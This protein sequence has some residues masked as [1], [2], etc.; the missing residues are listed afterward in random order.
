MS[1]ETAGHQ[2][3][4][5][6]LQGNP[7]ASRADLAVAV[8]DLVA[9]LERFRSP[10]GA[11]VRLAGGGASYDQVAAEL[12][13]FS[14]PLWGLVPLAAGGA[15]VDWEPYRRG[16]VAGTDPRHPEYWGRAGDRD[17]RL[18][19]MAAIAFA[20]CLVP[21]QLWLPLGRSDRSHL[22]D[23][24]RRVDQ[25]AYPDNNWLFFRVLVHLALRR[26]GE[27]YDRQGTGRALDRLEQFSADDGWYHDGPDGPRDYYTPFGM[28]FYGLLYSTLAATEDPARA[29]RFRDRAATFAPAFAHW[30]AQDGS[31]V[32]YGRS[33]T[34]RFAQGAFWGALAYANLPALPWGQVKGLLLRNL[35]WWAQQPIAD[36]AGVL[37]L[38]YGYPND[39]MTEEYNAPGSP[40]WGLKTFLPL[41]L[42]DDHP[43]W[44]EPEHPSDPATD[45]VDEQSEPGMAMCRTGTGGK[46]VFAL[47]T[48]Q[49]ARPFRHGEAKYAKFAYSS[50]FAFS[51]TTAAAGRAG[52]APDSMLALSDDPPGTD[53][54]FRGRSTIEQGS[55]RDGLVHARW[56]PWHDVRIDTWLWPELPWHVRLHRIRTDRRL[57]GVE[58]GWAVERRAD[59]R[60]EVVGIDH[61]ETASPAGV[62]AILGLTT[63]LAP[64]GRTGRIQRL[65][66]GSNLMAPRADLP[67][68]TGVLAPGEHWLGC[69]VLGWPGPDAARPGTA[70][71]HERLQVALDAMLEHAGRPAAD[72]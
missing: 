15:E 55:V 57:T 28:H 43:F 59:S 27:R 38:G 18:V 64:T 62:T 9:P 7:L 47:C 14:R 50:A 11:R 6:P 63:G 56:S 60:D 34:Y 39:A 52:T 26:V 69:A 3:G 68:L 4:S 70:A 17:Q 36:N 30:F 61:A 49:T 53:L 41:A 10:G 13:T 31:A 67:T 25:V 32:P 40:Y 35:R 1:E 22:A 20:L 24:L 12:E 29:Q 37:S 23:W 65:S 48:G 21:E 8:R 71:E 16:L 19:E 2:V 45:Q 51:V 33:M 66:P 42:P 54:Y 44:T 58:G 46:H 72:A 5:R